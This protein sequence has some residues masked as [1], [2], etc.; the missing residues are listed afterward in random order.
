MTNLHDDPALY[1][2]SLDRAVLIPVG[3]LEPSK[4]PESQLDSVEQAIARMRQAA[5]NEIPKR[6]PITVETTDG[7]AFRIIDGN[8]TYGAAL[9]SG[10]R[11]LPALIR[12]TPSD[13]Q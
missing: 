12:V 9:E 2:T 1:F 5:R 11:H 3:L 4:P 6:G 13:E 8:A 10:W 7:C